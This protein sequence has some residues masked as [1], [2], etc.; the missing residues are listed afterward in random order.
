[1]LTFRP[2][3][4]QR[5][6]A[7]VYLKMEAS[8][9]QADWLKK[10]MPVQTEA[11]I[12]AHEISPEGDYKEFNLMQNLNFGV[13]IT[14]LFFTLYSFS[15]IFIFFLIFVKKIITKQPLTKPNIGLKQIVSSFLWITDKVSSISSSLSIFVLM[16]N[17]FL[18]LFMLMVVNTTKTNKVVSRFCFDI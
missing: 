10:T 18:W 15:L 7:L 9:V 13:Q 5:K 6:E 4:L 16:F 12:I 1:M 8:I 17:L 11:F 3:L 2:G 14:A